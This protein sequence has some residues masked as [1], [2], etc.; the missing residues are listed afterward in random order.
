MEGAAGLGMG[1]DFSRAALWG[2]ESFS[3][4]HERENLCP[5]YWVCVWVWERR[6]GNQSS[7]LGKAA[8]GFAAATRLFPSLL[9]WTIKSVCD[10][11]SK[12]QGVKKSVFCSEG[13]FV[14]SM[15]AG[16]SVI[17][18]QQAWNPLICKSR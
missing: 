18:I 15:D 1:S 12:V 3:A 6:T 7:C 2:K 17:G 13:I 14:E 5:N 8:F 9:C 11:N 16:S 4:G 10:I